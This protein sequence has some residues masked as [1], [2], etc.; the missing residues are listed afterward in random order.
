MEIAHKRG[1]RADPQK[2]EAILDAA[3]DLFL[4]R[5]YSASIDDIATAAGVSK[6]TIYARYASKHDLLAAVVHQVAEDLVSVFAQ[7]S[8]AASTQETLMRFGE[9]FVEIAFDPKRVAMQRLVI[10]Q[11]TQFPDLARV[12][13]ESGPAFVHEKI[14][15]FLERAKS[16]GDLDFESAR[17]A[18]SNLLGLIM[19]VD[20]VASL[21]GILDPQNAEQRRARVRG[22]V[23]AFL[24][25]FQA[26]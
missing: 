1:R 5:G 11:S 6:Q 16:A 26:R 9:R 4:D 3:R 14:A 21:M 22:A 25:I 20:H 12:Y 8:K 2:D 15:D 23:L 7:G 17:D 18:A 24:K 13:F 19:G 10:A